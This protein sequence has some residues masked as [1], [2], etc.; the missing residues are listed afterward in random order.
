MVRLLK[1]SS[2]FL[3]IAGIVLLGFMG[4][5][6][7]PPE[8]TVSELGRKVNFAQV[9]IHGRVS[10]EVRFHSGEEGI[11]NDSL[12]FEV[13]DGTGK[14]R[15][16]CYEDGFNALKAAGKIPAKSD[17]VTVRGN[18]QYKAKRQFVILSSDVDLEITREPVSSATPIDQVLRA[19]EFNI[20]EGQRLLVTGRLTRK[21]DGYYDFTFLLAGTDD[22]TLAVVF[23]KDLLRAYGFA[24][25]SGTFWN[26][27]KEGD[28]VTAVGELKWYRGKKFQNWQ[29]IPASPADLTSSDQATWEQNNGG[30]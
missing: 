30:K 3:T 16:R 25:T 12:E 23:S 8:V 15:V 17:I 19:G 10:D 6:Y 2:P 29:L 11:G 21:I 9:R 22:K 7:G 24:S 13:D 26:T 20:K 18:Y 4:K 27:W 28:Y 5:A 14:I 1:Y